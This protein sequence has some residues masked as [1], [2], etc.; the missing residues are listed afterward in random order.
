M[1][2][3]YLVATIGNGTEQDPYRPKVA[4]YKCSW[5][6][7]YESPEQANSIVAVN[8]DETVFTEIEKDA[9]ILL[10]ADNLD[11]LLTDEEFQR[12]CPDGTVMVYE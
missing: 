10:L 3:Y 12:I 9:E 4:E 1:T 2:K 6:A 7:V 8:A 11:E 5:T